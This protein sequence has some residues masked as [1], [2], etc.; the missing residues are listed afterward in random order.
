[1]LVLGHGWN[2]VPVELTGSH[3]LEKREGNED[4][5]QR[6]ACCDDCR[7]PGGFGVRPVVVA[8]QGLFGTLQEPIAKC[9]GPLK[10]RPQN[11]APD[12][13]PHLFIEAA[14]ANGSAIKS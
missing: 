11:I 8:G 14:A 6:D 4:A 3:P 12:K 5:D 2:T 9:Q 13:C 1:M 10:I 7:H